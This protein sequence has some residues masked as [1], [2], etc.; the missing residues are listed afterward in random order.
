MGE[1]AAD[2]AV[3][4]ELWAFLKWLRR[5]EILAGAVAAIERFGVFVALDEGP[6]HPVH[7]GVGF[8]TCP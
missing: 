5:G 6:D 4:P 8:I 3:N 1:E 7:P 2:E